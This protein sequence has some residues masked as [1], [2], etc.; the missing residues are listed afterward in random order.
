MVEEQLDVFNKLI[1]D[2]ENSDVT[3]ENED[4]VLLLLY[5]LPKTFAHFKETLLYGRDS[6]TLVKV[7]SAL[8]SNEL[9]ERNEQRSFVHRERLIVHGRHTRRMIRQK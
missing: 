4:Q 7:Q 3:I 6:F 8:N 2:L 9:N 1:L 5:A